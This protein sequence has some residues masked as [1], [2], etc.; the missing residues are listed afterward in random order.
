MTTPALAPA[1]RL[2]VALDTADSAAAAALARSLKGVAGGVKL[3]KEFFTAH[4]PAGVA[5]VA[6]E[7]LPVF[8]DLKFHDIPNTVAGAVKAALAL[9]PFMLNV[10]ASGG[11]AMMRAA[12]KAAAQPGNARPLVVA[13]TV[14][15]SLDEDDLR[16]VGMRPPIVDQAV[17]LAKLAQAS[18]LDGVVCSAKEAMAIRGACGR[19]FKLVVPG[20]RPAWAEASD[21]KRIVTPREAIALGADYLVVGRPITGARDPVSAAKRVVAEIA[22]PESP[23]P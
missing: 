17:R 8:L 9:K 6:A 4:G 21:Q 5:R 10:H 15:T 1:Q 14:L 7:G 3:G 18:D 12:A 11:A 16:A 20:I 13:V 19:D 23:E 22:T 2:F